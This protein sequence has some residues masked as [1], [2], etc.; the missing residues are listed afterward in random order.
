MKSLLSFTMTSKIKPFK[1]KWCY[2]GT[3][4]YHRNWTWLILN[5][6]NGS[7]EQQESLQMTPGERSRSLNFQSHEK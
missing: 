6:K 3:F 1:H 7:R 4:L 5:L 2:L